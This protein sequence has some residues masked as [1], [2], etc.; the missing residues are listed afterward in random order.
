MYMFTYVYTHTHTHNVKTLWY[1]KTVSE[2]VTVHRYRQEAMEMVVEMMQTGTSPDN[3][4]TTQIEEQV[5]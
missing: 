3:A 4:H 5:M 1:L 2:N